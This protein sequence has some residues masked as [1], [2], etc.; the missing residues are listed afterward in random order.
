MRDGVLP[1][2]ENIAT[3]FEQVAP[4]LFDPSAPGMAEFDSGMSNLECTKRAAAMGLWG[5]WSL[6][7]GGLFEAL[8]DSTFDLAARFYEL[9]SEQ[10]DFEPYC[11]PECNIVVFRYLPSELSDAADDQIDAFQLALRRR[12]VQSGDFYLVQIRLDGR[13]YLRTTIINPL[14]TLKHLR[15]LLDGLREHGRQWMAE[16]DFRNV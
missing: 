8:V 13:D 10:P 7:G 2:A 15:G 14:T 12:V 5:V 11:C 9:L 16:G 3:A 1:L 6:F 4:Y